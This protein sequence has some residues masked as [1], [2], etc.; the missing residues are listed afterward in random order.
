MVR[1]PLC[2]PRG[3]GRQHSQYLFQTRAC[4]HARANGPGHL[5]AARAVAAKKVRV[6]AAVVRELISCYDAHQPVNIFRVRAEASRVEALGMMPK[7]TEIIAALPDSHRA[8]LVPYLTSKP[9]RTASGIAVVA[10]MCKPHRC[11][12]IA[13]TGNVCVYW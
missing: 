9:V 10:V 3:G 1:F 12:H 4:T 5:L 6:V 8:K 13:T 11:P 2:E 7:L